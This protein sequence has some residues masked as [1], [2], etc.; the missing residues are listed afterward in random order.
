LHSQRRHTL[1]FPRTLGF[2]FTFVIF[3][4]ETERLQRPITPLLASYHHV[5]RSSTANFNP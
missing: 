2:A 3:V 4:S 5:N 1:I